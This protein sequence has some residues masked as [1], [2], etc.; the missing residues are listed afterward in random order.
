[1]RRFLVPVGLVLALLLSVAALVVGSLAFY[2]VRQLQQ[3]ALAAVTEA[4]SALAG[5]TDQTIETSIPIH[6]T[7]PIDADVPLEQEFVIPVQTTL[8]ISVTVDVPVQL[9]LL[10]TYEMTVPV[11]TSVPIDL[12]VVIPISQT[13]PVETSVTLDMEVPIRLTLDQLGL[14]DLLQDV[15]Q[16]LE[17]VERQLRQP[18]GDSEEGQ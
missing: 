15:D 4:R 16:R 14:D 13:V 12:Q 11:D 2:G 10:G 17:Q 5:I 7:F 8:P 3:G 6:Q 9:P 1:M 18:F